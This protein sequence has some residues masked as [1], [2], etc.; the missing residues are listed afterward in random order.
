[1]QDRFDLIV[2][3]VGGDD[4]SGAEPRGGLPEEGIPCPACNRLEPHARAALGQ[5]ARRPSDQ[6]L[7]P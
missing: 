5:V 7:Y 6:A 2:G 4:V 3:G 1:M